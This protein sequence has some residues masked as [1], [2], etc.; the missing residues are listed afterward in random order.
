MSRSDPIVKANI[1]G[2][3]SQ[4]AQHALWLIRNNQ[5]MV[6]V[7]QSNDH[8]Q[9]HILRQ[10]WDFWLNQ[11]IDPWSTRP[12]PRGN[13][14]AARTWLYDFKTQQWTQRW[15]DNPARAGQRGR[16]KTDELYPFPP[17][18]P[19]SLLPSNGRM[20]LFFSYQVG[21]LFPLPWC[22]QRDERFV[23][24]SNISSNSR[25][26]VWADNQVLRSTIDAFSTIPDIVA[27]NDTHVAARRA[28]PSHN[29]LLFRFPIPYVIF[30]HEDSHEGRLNALHKATYIETRLGIRLPILIITSDAVP[31]EYAVAMQ[32]ADVKDALRR[33]YSDEIVFVTHIAGLFRCKTTRVENVLRYRSDPANFKT[34]PDPNHVYALCSSQGVPVAAVDSDAADCAAASAAADARAGS[35]SAG[36]GKS[37]LTPEEEII[38]AKVL[39]HFDGLLQKA[40]KHKNHYLIYQLVCA[41][42]DRVDL[43]ALVKHGTYKELVVFLLLFAA[44]QTN[45][46]LV[47]AILIAR[48]DMLTYVFMNKRTVKE[49]YADAGGDA[50]FIEEIQL[51]G[52]TFSKLQTEGWDALDQADI[53]AAAHA[54]LLAYAVRDEKE[55]WVQWLLEQSADRNAKK[56]DGKTPIENAAANAQWEIVALFAPYPTD[57]HDSANYK[58]AFDAAVL[59]EKHEI[60]IQLVVKNPHIHP[61]RW[62]FLGKHQSSLPREAFGPLLAL[63]VADNKTDWV[64]WLLENGADRTS[65]VIDGKPPIVLA[66]EKGHWNLVAAIGAYITDPEDKAG[67]GIA[68]RMAIANKENDAAFPVLNNSAARINHDNCVETSSNK[69]Y[70]AL[71]FA[72][73]ND[74]RALVTI[75]LDTPHKVNPN[76]RFEDGCPTATELA[77][78]EKKLEMLQLL[79]GRGGTVPD[80]AYVE[81]AKEGDGW[82]FLDQIERF[83]PESALGRLLHEAAKQGNAEWVAKLLRKEADHC[84]QAAD[85]TTPIQAAAQGSHW[86]VVECL[87][88]QTNDAE[89]NAHHGPVFAEMAKQGRWEDV[90]RH[91]EAG[92]IPAT[93]YAA[94]LFYAVSVQ[95]ETGNGAGRVELD[96][97]AQL[98]L[99]KWLLQ[100]KADRS[101]VATGGAET[102]IEIAAKKADWEMVEAF[103]EH[104]T[105]A[106]DKAHYVMVMTVL[107]DAKQ[108]ALALKLS[109]KLGRHAIPKD[110]CNQ[111]LDQAV[112]AGDAKAASHWLRKGADATDKVGGKTDTPIVIATKAGKWDVVAVFAAFPSADDDKACYGEAA[113]KA[114]EAKQ[115]DVAMQLI[116]QSGSFDH[117]LRSADGKNMLYHTVM[118]DRGDIVAQLLGRRLS[119]R[120]VDQ[121]GSGKNALDLALENKKT[122]ALCALVPGGRKH[123]TSE[124]RIKNIFYKG[125]SRMVAAFIDAGVAVEGIVFARGGFDSNQ[126]TDPA[127][128]SI[129]ELLSAAAGATAAITDQIDFSANTPEEIAAFFKAAFHLIRAADNASKYDILKRFR[130]HYFGRFEEFLDAAT[131]KK[132]DCIAWLQWAKEQPLF[133]EH[134]SALSMGVIVTL[135]KIDERLRREGLSRPEEAGIFKPAAAA[136]R[137]D[138]ASA[139]IAVLRAVNDALA[140][141]VTEFW[142]SRNMLASIGLFGA[143]VRTDARVEGDDADYFASLQELRMFLDG[144]TATMDHAA[145]SAADAAAYAHVADP[146]VVDM[147]TQA[148][149][150][151]KSVF[152]AIRLASEQDGQT[153]SLHMQKL[154]NGIAKQYGLVE[155]DVANARAADCTDDSAARG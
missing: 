34:A 152:A 65:T 7:I 48:P 97:A 141:G 150:E 133:S 104:A 11:W 113:L 112:E 88:R 18:S 81:A 129:F 79:M 77:F 40:I 126:I 54:K 108:A 38:R 64:T 46:G 138:T 78:K 16:L 111:L 148:L 29:E 76:Q 67:Y 121:A 93:A 100:N 71:H 134:C 32:I 136:G 17:K 109:N 116:A 110:V 42:P 90:L 70:Y 33:S 103:A 117:K 3:V 10:H 27:Q 137:A 13:K 31:K 9:G 154:V 147:V 125:N 91:K 8:D 49:I 98:A 132:V 15:Q 52:E 92:H 89:D 41:F 12:V 5:A 123:I 21:L 82:K 94:L 14:R 75:L 43:N 119:R 122:N 118:A 83:I 57:A 120:N 4:R 22:D 146:A 1:A 19:G 130:D 69:G 106:D 102:A 20:R 99:I 30:A 63:A 143:Q 128:K 53:P 56:V 86:G 60:A 37:S 114:M 135:V 96:R 45:E 105:D 51:T 39:E 131:L 80:T 72:V 2:N 115:F 6:K 61:G 84:Y 47:E 44:E 74:D 149:G 59:A 155:D 25:P 95:A 144:V 28:A 35:A 36:A 58:A 153:V 55:D 24:K 50:A 87:L 139:N 127:L 145:G 140:A 66:A 107:A 101:V 151:A 124:D 23:F 73:E 62:D 85:K 68:A 142:Q 26:W